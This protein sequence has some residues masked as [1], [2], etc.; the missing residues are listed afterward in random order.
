MAGTMSLLPTIKCS[1]C[2]A[3]IEISMMGDHLCSTASQ[4]KNAVGMRKPVGTNRN[5][6]SRPPEPSFRFKGAPPPSS[7]TNGSGNDS[8]KPGRTAPPR[9]DPQ[10]ANRPFIRQ[11]QLTPISNYGDSRNVSPITPFPNPFRNYSS[12]PP[13]SLRTLTPEL[14]SGLSTERQ[15]SFPA[16]SRSAAS[17]LPRST[18]PP[19][20]EL[21]S[22]L[23]PA[24]P[25]F[26]SRAHTAPVELRGVGEKSRAGQLYVEPSPLYAPLSPRTTGG[27]NVLQRMNAIAPG[28][29]G[30]QS[31]Q[32]PGSDRSGDTAQSRGHQRNRSSKGS[33]GPQSAVPRSALPPSRDGATS[34][35]QRPSTSGS[36]KSQRRTGFD[37][38]DL[39][40]KNFLDQLAASPWSSKKEV[41]DSQGVPQPPERET[42]GFRPKSRSRAIPM[43][44]QFKPLPKRP[45]DQPQ[46]PAE[47]RPS[48]SGSLGRSRDADSSFVPWGGELPQ[49]KGQENAMH[50]KPTLSRSSTRS[51]S[52]SGSGSGSD[53]RTASSRSTPPASGT[54]RKPRRRPSDTSNI[55]GLLKE[56][57]SSMELQQPT[58]AITKDTQTS[59]SAPQPIDVTTK[60]PEKPRIT[61][62]PKPLGIPMS[63]RDPRL[64]GKDTA[65][66]SPKP[67]VSPTDTPSKRVDGKPPNRRPAAAKGNCRGCGEPIRGK[68]V[69]SADGRLTGRYHKQCR[70]CEHLTTTAEL[71]IL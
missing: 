26:P 17:T 60:E 14:E 49:S 64:S 45:V 58:D 23:D 8:L 66:K 37:G 59:T 63:P 65:P 5:A 4:R 43:E 12:T 24:S 42:D 3:E 7:R 32:I 62:L 19:T 33:L 47:R 53:T 15:T 48:T 1:N 11:D 57:Q 44:V 18:R 2:G 20:P 69:S 52:R 31:A 30:I 36:E 35:I 9:I 13:R 40:N 25:L 71:I 70:Y 21:E 38:S 46:D 51:R 56:I 67:P 10:A 55:D 28:P 61:R 50:R 54:F 41:H 68:S 29:F 27:G 34:H 22:N 6:A 16:P 39:R